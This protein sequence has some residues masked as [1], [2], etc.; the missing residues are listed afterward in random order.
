VVDLGAMRNPGHAEAS[1]KSWALA[2]IR[3]TPT[4]T[5]SLLKDINVGVLTVTAY[6]PR[7]EE[8]TQSAARSAAVD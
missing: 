6:R 8:G 7:D 1:V 5:L 2:F 4:D 3:S